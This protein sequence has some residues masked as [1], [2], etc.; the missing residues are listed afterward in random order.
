M[1]NFHTH[2]IQSDALK[3]D[4]ANPEKNVLWQTLVWKIIKEI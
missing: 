2:P 4:Q 1:K 3:E